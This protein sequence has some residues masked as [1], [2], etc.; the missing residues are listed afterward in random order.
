MS[1]NHCSLIIQGNV[2]PEYSISDLF[3]NYN[4]SKNR[5]LNSIPRP[6]NLLKHYDVKKLGLERKKKDKSSSWIFPSTSGI[7]VGPWFLL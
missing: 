6:L 1:E 5:F 4:Y 7:N 2:I 3:E